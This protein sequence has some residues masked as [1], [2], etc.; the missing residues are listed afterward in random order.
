MAICG[1]LWQCPSSVCLVF[2][3][4][5]P[6]RSLSRLFKF[7]LFST[8]KTLILLYSKKSALILKEF[9][10]NWLR[11]FRS[12]SPKSKEIAKYPMIMHFDNALLST[13]HRHW[14]GDVIIT[15][16]CL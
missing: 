1:K 13:K 10:Q 6:I 4:L 3:K 9:L 7:Q 2:I 16:A 14:P 8:S 15:C 12:Q 5:N 11:N